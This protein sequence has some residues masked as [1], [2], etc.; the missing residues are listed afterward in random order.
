M[1][2]ILFALAVLAIIP[3]QA[4]DDWSATYLK[5]LAHK[6][7]AQGAELELLC[8]RIENN[9]AS[10]DTMQQEVRSLVKATQESTALLK[11]SHQDK[12]HE[13]NLEKVVK[14]L[15]LLKN[16]INDNVAAVNALQQS[17]KA[18]EELARQQ[19]KQ[20]QEL[21]KALRSL[22]RLQQPQ[23]REVSTYCVKSGDSL[24]RIAKENGTTVQA[25]KEVN[26]LT[27]NT[28]RPGQELK[29]P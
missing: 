25:L 13:K 21:E 6:V 17:L 15:A 9:E 7:D 16:H 23:G 22:A 14:D 4:S 27:N 10:S 11:A 24:D 18:H 20:I 19:T 3:L 12:S 28:I 2:S 8:Q 29:L 26:G 5:R 1:R